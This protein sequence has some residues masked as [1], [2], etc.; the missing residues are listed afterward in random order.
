MNV[1]LQAITTCIGGFHH[2]TQNKQQTNTQV[3]FNKTV[4]CS[5]MLEQGLFSVPH[6]TLL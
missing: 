6:K 4:S 2:S 5:F 3:K 1:F